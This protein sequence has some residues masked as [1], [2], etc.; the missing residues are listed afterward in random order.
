MKIFFLALYLLEL[1]TS[2]AVVSFETK[3][4]WIAAIQEFAEKPEKDVKPLLVCMI[5]GECTYGPCV[6]FQKDINIVSSIV[7]AQNRITVIDCGSTDEVCRM[8][9]K[10]EREPLNKIAISYIRD[11]KIYEFAGA[12]T[13]EGL[14]DYMSVENWQKAKVLEPDIKNYSA[15]LTGVK[16]TWS[17]TLAR[18]SD[19]TAE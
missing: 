4:E 18:L 6:E 19:E 11:S 17:D 10:P 15:M 12:E 16:I 1:V 2:S 7:K 13:Q 8:I 3:E 5:Y 9:P 14:L